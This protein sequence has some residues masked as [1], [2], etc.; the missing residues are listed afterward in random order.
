[1]ADKLKEIPG[2][3]LEWW[4]K[5]T[6]KQKT[7]MVASVAV[8]IFTFAIVIYTFTRPQYV[9]LGTYDTS[10]DAADVIT[11]LND[12]GITHRESADARTIEVL[13]SQE[14]QAII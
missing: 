11:I 5:F 4:N 9:Q 12:A 10:A 14:S 2:M 3:I 1:M 13:K 6:N 7:I 8:A